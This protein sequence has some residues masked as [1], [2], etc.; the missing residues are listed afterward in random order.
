M[1][2]PLQS[3]A[4]LT[5]QRQIM[6]HRKIILPEFLNDQGSLFGGNLL[7]WVDEF[8]YITANLDFPGNRFVTIAL[9]DV[10]FKNPI[11]E[12]EILCFDIR[13]SQ[14]GNSSVTY[15]VKI[16]GEKLAPKGQILFQTSIVFVNVD[17]DGNKQAIR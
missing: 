14:K 2:N 12:G 11:R 3:A 17:P 1:L 6:Q 4:T 15:E 8:A 5:A 7:K 9:D 13:Q 16:I 10:T